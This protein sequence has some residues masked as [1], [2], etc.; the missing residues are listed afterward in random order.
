MYTFCGTE[1]HAWQAESSIAVD[2][3]LLSSSGTLRAA[4]LAEDRDW[5]FQVAR[6]HA[7]K[8]VWRSDPVPRSTFSPTAAPSHGKGGTWSK[9]G[10]A[11]HVSVYQSTALTGRGNEYKWFHQHEQE[12][13]SASRHGPVA[14]HTRPNNAASEVPTQTGS[15]LVCTRDNLCFLPPTCFRVFCARPTQA[16]TSAFS[17]SVGL[18]AELGDFGLGLQSSEPSA[19]RA[20]VMSFQVAH[21]F[22]A[23]TGTTTLPSPRSARAVNGVRQGGC[24]STLDEAPHIAT[25]QEPSHQKRAAQLSSTT[26]KPP[27]SVPRTPS[28]LRVK[29]VPLSGLELWTLCMVRLYSLAFPVWRAHRRRSAIRVC[30]VFAVGCL[31][32]ESRLRHARRRRVKAFAAGFGGWSV[33]RRAHRKRCAKVLVLGLACK[34]GR[35]HQKK[36]RKERA[37]EAKRQAKLGPKMARLHWRA[38]QE[39]QDV[40]GTI[41]DAS[42]RRMSQAGDAGRIRSARASPGSGILGSRFLEQAADAFKLDKQVSATGK[43]GAGQATPSPKLKTKK[44]TF[45]SSNQ[46]RNL[47]IT[48]SRVVSRVGLAELADALLRLDASFD[49]D[50]DMLET[51]GALSIFSA[52]SEIKQVQAFTGKPAL[53]DVPEQFIA[54]VVLPVPSAQQRIQFLHFAR[55]FK[56]TVQSC[57]EKLEKMAA[58]C[59][60]LRHSERMA[61][62]LGVVLQIGNSIQTAGG[63]RDTAVSGF[64]LS[65]LPLLLTSRGPAGQTF[66][67]FMVEGLLEASP[68]LLE[69]EEELPLLM[70]ATPI[71]CSLDSSDVAISI[72]R[73]GCLVCELLR[74]QSTTPPEQAA[75]VSEVEDAARAC[76]SELERSLAK[77]QNQ[78]KLTCRFFL[79]DPVKIKLQDLVQAAQAFVRQ[80]NQLHR[81][82]QRKLERLERKRK[83]SPPTRQNPQAEKPG[84]IDRALARTP[85][86]AVSTKPR[87]PPR[88]PKHSTGPSREGSALATPRHRRGSVMR[89]DSSGSP[90]ELG[91]KGD[92]KPSQ[93]QR[94]EM[95]RELGAF[96]SRRASVIGS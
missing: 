76:M 46:G 57:S 92:S 79:E 80:L 86:P 64:K 39:G 63:V 29:Q 55:T 85:P 90:K 74:T 84:T 45:F 48:L 42:G 2:I 62:I 49:I 53:L 54:Q 34:A 94:R 14:F 50:V 5:L 35:K 58:M 81:T 89:L 8:L 31:C 17:G 7:R 6:Q 32:L 70:A 40:E 43:G 52:A 77:V 15:Q 91:G 26:S 88:R 27:T 68:A 73:K 38:V 20:E 61:D 60:E 19:A 24:V 83:K 37:A 12:K 30:G 56:H 33:R 66:G 59:R 16:V 9:R 71:D 3:P 67:G 25:S 21:G 1:P 4:R 28:G 72:L 47:G 44:V 22:G 65:S 69:V 96:F 95:K 11:A 75:A 41:F 51:L 10:H 13:H 82:A 87:P 93:A 78:Y 36:V 18:D 23:S